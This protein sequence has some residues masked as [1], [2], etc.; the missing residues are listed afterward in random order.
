[1]P[2]V[3]FANGRVLTIGRER[4]S[5]ASGARLAAQRVQLPLD[6]AWAMSVHKSQGMTLD[7]WA[8]GCSAGQ[9]RKRL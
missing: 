1:L 8:S 6:L 5:I 4:W 3:R 9:Y 2:V 7:R